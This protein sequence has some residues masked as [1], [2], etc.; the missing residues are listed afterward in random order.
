ME[1]VLRSCRS[2]NKSDLVAHPHD[3]MMALEW[4]WSSAPLSAGSWGQSKYWCCRSMLK[5]H[6]MS[7]AGRAFQLSLLPVQN[8]THLECAIPPR[9]LR[10]PHWHLSAL[11]RKSSVGEFASAGWGIIHLWVYYCRNQHLGPLG[12]FQQ[13][14][15]AFWCLLCC[16]LP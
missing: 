9:D 7:R 11:L 14:L 16:V 6:V 4:M 10:Q 15:Q 5:E 1:F 3:C 13:M 12:N 8:E 2:R